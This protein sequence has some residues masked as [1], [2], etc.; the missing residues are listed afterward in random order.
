MR[1]GDGFHCSEVEI[2]FGCFF[3]LKKPLVRGAWRTRGGKVKE[4]TRLS[5]NEPVAAQVSF[6]SR[7]VFNDDPL[8]MSDLVGC[9]DG[10]VGHMRPAIFYCFF[11]EAAVTLGLGDFFCPQ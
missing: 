6:F 9:V 10:T 1:I 2:A 8:G 5:G 7:S 4:K 3:I 11:S